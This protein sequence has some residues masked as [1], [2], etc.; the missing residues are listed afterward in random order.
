MS[1]GYVECAHCGERV[2]TYYVTCP[3]CGYKLAAREPTTGMGPLYGMTD[4]EFYRELGSMWWPNKEGNETN[5]ERFH[6]CRWR[7]LHVEPHGLG[8]SDR[9]IRTAGSRVPFHVGR[10]QQ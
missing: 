8:D 6:W 5:N 10:G 4:D 3:Y 9:F 2:G 7:S 1:P